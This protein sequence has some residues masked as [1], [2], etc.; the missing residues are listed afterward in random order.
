MR[1][2]MP[3]TATALFICHGRD[4][5][6]DFEVKSKVRQAKEKCKIGR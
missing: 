1:S 6:M 5:A 3:W 4:P 2:L